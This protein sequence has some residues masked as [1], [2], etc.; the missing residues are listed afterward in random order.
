M[1]FTLV[2]PGLLDL[3]PPALDAID[4]EAPVLARMLGG[5]A[6]PSIDEDGLVATACRACGIAKQQDWP[7]APWLAGGAGLDMDDAYWLC[8]EPARFAVGHNDVRLAALVDDLE[9]DDANAL[10]A[11]LNAHFADD[12][13][14]F[15]VTK[16]ARWFART[17]HKPRLVTHPPE[18][19]LDAPL[20]PYL[21]SGPD[22]AQW[23]RWQSEVQMLL[24]EHTVNRR[25]EENGCATVDGVWLWGGGTP[26]ARDARP[27]RIFAGGGLVR[28]LAI[29]TGIGCS[30][31][32][33]VLEAGGDAAPRVFWL[34]PIG[35]DAIAT[36]LAALDRSWM[37]P[38]E[39][40]LRSGAIREL[41][42]VVAG[43]RSAL[44]FRVTR[45]PLLRRWRARFSSPHVAPM[46]AR[47][48]AEAAGS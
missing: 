32:P 45:P 22:A 21:P 43:S 35:I 46:L 37:T 27:V 42:V 47:L 33:A 41:D 18:R 10:I 26:A 24:F 14:R 5:A 17:D 2:V 44:T 23:R 15:V 31:L 8:A 6:A 40:A 9:T 28:D 1:H 34:D 30:P 48:A 20:L 11:T 19:A 7:V 3:P 13:V 39:R 25:R 29:S 36:R 16:P 4:D 12:G 38:A